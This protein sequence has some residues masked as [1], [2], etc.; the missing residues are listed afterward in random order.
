MAFGGNCKKIER[1]YDKADTAY[2]K[3][4]AALSKANAALSKTLTDLS[5]ADTAQ[6]KANNPGEVVAVNMFKVGKDA[7]DYS[8]AKSDLS[9]GCGK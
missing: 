2:S 4:D 8:R 6:A 5:K 9:K 7:F 1:A 3:A